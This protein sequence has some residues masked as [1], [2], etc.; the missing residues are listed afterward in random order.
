[1]LS[2]AVTTVSHHALLSLFVSC[3]SQFRAD[4]VLRNGGI[5]PM[6]PGHPRVAAVAITGNTILAVLDCDDQAD[7]YVGSNTLTGRTGR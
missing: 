6:A 7:G 1:M 5:Y 2:S 4:I 3:A